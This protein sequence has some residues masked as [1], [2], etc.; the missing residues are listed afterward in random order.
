M[1]MPNKGRLDFQEIGQIRDFFCKGN[2]RAHLL[3]LSDDLMSSD[4]FSCLFSLNSEA[5]KGLL[6][7]VATSGFWV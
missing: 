6:K 4:P 2:F 5:N 3:A 1:E 7:S